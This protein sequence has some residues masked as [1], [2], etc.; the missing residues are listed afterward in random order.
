MLLETEKG[1][2]I[3]QHVIPPNR[4]SDTTEYLTWQAHLSYQLITLNI[5]P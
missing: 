1:I 2:K 4:I 3:R 5:I